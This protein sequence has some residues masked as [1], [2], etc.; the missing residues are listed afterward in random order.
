MTAYA[1]ENPINLLCYLDWLRRLIHI[2]RSKLMKSGGNC[3][4]GEKKVE[5]VCKRLPN[6]KV[7]TITLEIIR[8]SSVRTLKCYDFFAFVAKARALVEK[9]VHTYRKSKLLRCR[10]KRT[11]YILCQKEYCCCCCCRS[12][13]NT[14]A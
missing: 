2:S 10:Y 9:K 14:G 12:L 8:F 3:L 5:N 4:N 7:S 13:I 1:I 6:D 11:K